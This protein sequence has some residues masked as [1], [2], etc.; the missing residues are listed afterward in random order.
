MSNAFE[1]LYNFEILKS[2]SALSIIPIYEP[3]KLQAKA[4]S[5]R[6]SF[7]LSCISF[8][9]FPSF[10]LK[11]LTILILSFYKW[12]LSTSGTCD[13]IKKLIYDEQNKENNFIRSGW[14]S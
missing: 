12:D 8:I 7:L 14:S 4:I 6:E 10:F 2:Y 11:S 3:E 13:I 1:I 5:S 9:R